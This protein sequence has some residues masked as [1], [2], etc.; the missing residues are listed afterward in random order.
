MLLFIRVFYLSEIG[1]VFVLEA[2]NGPAQL[3]FSYL[4]IEAAVDD[5]Y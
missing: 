3:F 1:F 2:F 4:A 5:F